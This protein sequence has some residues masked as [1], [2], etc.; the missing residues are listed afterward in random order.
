[1]VRREIFS[2]IFAAVFP[3]RAAFFALK[4]RYPVKASPADE[5][6]TLFDDAAEYTRIGLPNEQYRVTSTCVCVRPCAGGL[7]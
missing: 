7:V 1:M 6:W 3:Q 2:A 5:G 4:F